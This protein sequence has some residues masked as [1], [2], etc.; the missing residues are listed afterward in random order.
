MPAGSSADFIVI[1]GGIAGASAAH[2]LAPHA[3]VV[4]LEREPQ[5]GYHSSGRSAALFI[6]TYGPPQ[7]RALTRASRAFFENP[8]PGFAEHPLLTPRGSLFVASDQ[9]ERQLEEYWDEVASS[10]T[11]IRRLD[12]TETCSVVPVLRADRVTGS[13]YEPEACDIDVNALL[14][15]YVREM[16]RKGGIL[17]CN[18]EVTRIER[19]G[20]LWYVYAGEKAY[21][22]PVVLNAAGA[23][24]DMI[25][26]MAGVAPLGIEPRRRSAFT[27]PPPAGIETAQWPAVIGADEDWYF[28][29]EAGLLLGSPANADPVEP[30]D[31]QAEEL[32]VALAI[33][34]IEAIT[35]LTIRRPTRIWAGLRSFVADGS[36]VGGFDVRASGFFWVAAQG[37]YGIQTS[38]AMGEACAAL[39][40][41]L[42][43][44]QHL[45]DF[46][47]STAM[48]APSRGR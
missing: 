31:I 30:Q 9:Q 24:V 32:D 1:G 4:V 10:P 14:Q 37:G 44:P 2:W 38:A 48:L 13:V 45:A 8:G 27:F 20:A 5:P 40:R 36:L 23:W 16:R 28:K 34:R 29:P 7:V 41:G 25:A 11:V 19:V 33:D 17:H 15:G 46:G 6:E 12:R 39:A 18:A 21:S 3:Q 22:A 35:T 47:L 26:R 42:P 43:F